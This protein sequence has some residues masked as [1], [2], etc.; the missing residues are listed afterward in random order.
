[1]KLYII[2][3]LWSIEAVLSQN[4]PITSIAL[5]DILGSILKSEQGQ[6]YYGFRGIRYAQSPEGN[7]RWK[8]PV[9]ITE[10]WSEIFDGREDGPV[11]YQE[12]NNGLDYDIMSEDCLRISVYT[13]NL[14][15]SVLKPVFVHIHGGGFVIGSNSYERTSRPTY[16]MDYDIVYV[17]MNYRLGA[18]GFL[19]TGTSDAPGNAGFKD[20]VL[21]LK[22]IQDNIER[23]GGDPNKVTISGHSAGGMSVVLHM[24]SP[25]SKGLFHGAIPLSGSSTAQLKIENDQYLLTQKL[26]DFLK[27]DI[28]KSRSEVVDCL[29]EFSAYNLTRLSG[30]Y[31]GCGGSPILTFLPVIESDF[32]QT[33][34]LI[35]DPVK[36]ILNDEWNKV[37]VITGIAQDEFAVLG[38]PVLQ[39]NDF[40]AEMENNFENVAPVCFI[41]EQDTERSRNIS[42]VLKESFLPTPLRNYESLYDLQK[43]NLNSFKFS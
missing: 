1:M 6:D 13:K 24:V 31:S 10:P 37:P 15:G 38:L 39:N 5:G 8:D 16:L 29:R 36:T 21:A 7:L 22:W 12:P 11:C 30:V 3:I 2:L 25:M 4:N 40:R 33:R 20:Q 41:Y 32:G 35:E 9:P 18:L 28:N 14:N 34:F 19:S 27:C 23:F 42:A 17:T 43:V 26:A